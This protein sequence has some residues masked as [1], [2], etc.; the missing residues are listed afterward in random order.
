MTLS[1]N[2]EEILKSFAAQYAKNLS[3][4]GSILTSAEIANELEDMCELSVDEVSAFMFD[5][6]FAYSPKKTELSKHGWILNKNNES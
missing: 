6:G 2:K 5:F 4:E 1:K 3:N